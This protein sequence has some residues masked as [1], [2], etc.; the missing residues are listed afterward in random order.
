MCGRLVAVRITLYLA[1]AA[2][3]GEGHYP[4]WLNVN[5]LQSLP[6]VPCGLTGNYLILKEPLVNAGRLASDITSNYT[7]QSNVKLKYKQ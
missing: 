3:E 6:A 4:I 2:V 1:Q 7:C 5:K